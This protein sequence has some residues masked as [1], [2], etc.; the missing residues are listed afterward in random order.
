MYIAFVTV[1]SNAAIID[2]QVGTVCKREE[3]S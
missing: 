2:L 1:E 3:I